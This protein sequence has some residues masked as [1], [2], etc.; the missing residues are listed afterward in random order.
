MRTTSHT[1]ECKPLNRLM[2]GAVS[3]M[4]A[5][6]V[7][8]HIGRA[9][10]TSL[11]QFQPVKPLKRRGNLGTVSS[12]K[13]MPSDTDFDGNDIYSVPTISSETK[14]EIDEDDEFYL[15]DVASIKKSHLLGEIRGL[16]R[17]KDGWDGPDSKGT[18]S[19]ALDNALMVVNNWPSK[20]TLLPLPEVDV[21][22]DGHVVLDIYDRDGFAL[23][24]FD[25]PG[26]GNKAFFSV[27][28]RS[29]VLLSGEIDTTSSTQIIAALKAISTAIS[30]I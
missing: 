10:T 26:A 22:V 1:P 14:F 4:I 30:E 23:A 18:S 28:N 8:Y 12:A 9:D 15:S 13:S 24:G 21:D 25:F 27:V 2:V 11:E 16:G 7:P 20:P 5:G 19:N 3:L 29:K 6:T 17:L